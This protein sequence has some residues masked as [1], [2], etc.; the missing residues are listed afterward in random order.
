M[1]EVERIEN[2]VLWARYAARLALQRPSKG[3]REERSAPIKCDM[4]EDERFLFHGTQPEFLESI[5]EEGLKRP[6]SG[7]ALR[8]G[9]GIYF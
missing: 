7:N 4:Y 9:H 3:G 1:T 2:H 5:A 8:F 6:Q